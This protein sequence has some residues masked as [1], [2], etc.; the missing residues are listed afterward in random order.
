MILSVIWKFFQIFFKIYQD[1][2]LHVRIHKPIKNIHPANISSKSP[3]TDSNYWDVF[4]WKLQCFTMQSMEFKSRIRRFAILITWKNRTKLC[5]F[6]ALKV[7]E[8][9]EFRIT[10]PRDFRLNW[11]VESSARR[12]MSASLQV[13]SFNV[14]VW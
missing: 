8:E 9:I 5:R 1:K 13:L 7:W 12:I 10:F 6:T 14:K 11:K 4:Q 2:I 3:S